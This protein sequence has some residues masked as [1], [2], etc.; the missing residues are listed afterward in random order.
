MNEEPDG[1]DKSQSNAEENLSVPLTQVSESEAGQSKIEEEDKTT[2]TESKMA[3]KPGEESSTDQNDITRT[4]KYDDEK[5]DTAV[6]IGGQEDGQHKETT[7]DKENQSPVMGAGLTTDGKVS[8]NEERDEPKLENIEPELENIEPEPKNIEPEPEPTPEPE[9]P[10]EK[11]DPKTT[12][13]NQEI[14]KETFQ[15][16]VDDNVRLKSQNDQIQHE[17][18]TIRFTYDDMEKSVKKLSKANDQQTIRI[19]VLEKDLEQAKA[20]PDP[21]SEVKIKDLELKLLA[22]A[23]QDREKDREVA[24]LKR[25]LRESRH[26]L[27]SLDANNGSLPH[28]ST[29]PKSGACNIL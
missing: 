25:E 3:A 20:S 27:Q 23:K 22:I 2:E 14:E 28:N 7:D 19:S 13:H 11:I 8:E 6:V 17:L 9:P 12:L 16:L 10:E 15:N 24:Q 4:E 1:S 29:P 21:Q 26:K 5:N 18:E